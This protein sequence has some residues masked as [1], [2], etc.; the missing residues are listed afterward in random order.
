MGLAGW[1]V[2]D[3]LLR[4]SHLPLSPGITLAG[5]ALGAWWWRRP[6]P[7]GP[8]A[9]DVPGWLERLER[10]DAQ[11]G[12]L[13]AAQVDP[14]SP[15]AALLDTARLDRSNQLVALRQEL[16]RLGLTLALVGI[17]PPS[18]ELQGTVLEALRGPEPLQLHWAHPLPA[19]SADWCWP[20][21]FEACDGLIH[22]LRMPLSAA[23]LR[24]LEALPQGQP[25]WLLVQRDGQGPGIDQLAAELQAQ[26]GADLS[27]RLLFWDG[28]AQTLASSLAP[29]ARD[30][31]PAAASLRQARQ[32]RRLQQLHGRWQ[33]DL[34]RHRRELF[35]PLQRRTQWIVAA[36]V[37]AAP[38]PSLDLLVLAVA[39][40]LML[41][42]MARLWDCPWTLEQLQAAAGEL[43]KASLALG[44]V[45][46]SS[47]ALAGLVKWHGATWLV[48]G[49]MQALSA[50]YLTR[51]VAHA[52]ADMLALSAG[53]SEPDLAAIKRQAPLLVA[54]AAEAEKLDWPAFLEQGRQWL[55]SQT[56]PV[57]DGGSTACEHAI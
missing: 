52:M 54:R 40:G 45:E 8:S 44:V 19:W 31:G 18:G 20:P 22:H 48:G 11:F 4:L 17:N 12:Q 51:V 1:L 29:L 50:A 36:G 46:W 39:N 23:E 47:Q 13:V 24:W 3:G 6:R 7:L 30:L 34:E 9:T 32:L 55:R 21:V 35:R 42:E 26:L 25:A 41:Q 57:A 27:A 15:A 56:V 38:L 33:R 16:G 49:A 53:V 2:T 37:V 5:L 14:A 28:Q 10:L 43:A